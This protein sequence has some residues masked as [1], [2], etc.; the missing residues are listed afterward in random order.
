MQSRFA[1]FEPALR[2]VAEAFAAA[3][4]EAAGVLAFHIAA[5][6]MDRIAF[7]R[8]LGEGLACGAPILERAGFEVEIQRPAPVVGR[9]GSL[10]SDGNRHG[11]PWRR[12][13]HSDG[14]AQS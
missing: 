1:R 12:I 14:V 4:P 6:R 13:R 5:A 7:D 2:L 11:V 9:Q 3:D 8:P 10:E